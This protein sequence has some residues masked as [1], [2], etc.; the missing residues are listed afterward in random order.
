MDLGASYKIDKLDLTVG[1]ND[2]G[3]IKW[4]ENAQAL[5][6]TGD[7]YI[8]DDEDISD[9]M[10]EDLYLTSTPKSFRTSL[11]AVPYVSARYQ[12]TKAISGGA[13][14]YGNKIVDKYKPFL[15]LG[16]NLTPARFLEAAITYTMREKSFTNLGAALSG[17]FGP[18][19]I[20]LATDNILSAIDHEKANAFNVRTGLNFLFGQRRALKR[21]E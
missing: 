8:D 16:V 3:Y 14:L 15:T 21:E 4:K 13:L 19:Q 6:G 2:L 1:V 7:L 10:D 9:A 18:I 5:T 20:Y 17:R 11:T 12:L